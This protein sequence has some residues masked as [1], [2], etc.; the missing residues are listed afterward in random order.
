MNAENM[1]SAFV[2]AARLMGLSDN[3]KMWE[4]LSPFAF[5]SLVASLCLELQFLRYL[6]YSFLFTI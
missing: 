3:S 4:I 5:L 1:D 6:L 2:M